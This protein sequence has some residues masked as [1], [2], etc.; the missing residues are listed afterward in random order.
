MSKRLIFKQFSCKKERK[1]ALAN[2]T[3]TQKN[4][5]LEWSW[6]IHLVKQKV[7]Q[8]GLIKTAFTQ[9]SPGDLSF[10]KSAGRSY[11]WPKLG[12]VLNFGGGGGRK[13]SS[14]TMAG[15]T[16]DDGT[17]HLHLPMTRFIPPQ[18]PYVLV[19][20]SGMQILALLVPSHHLGLS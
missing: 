15:K 8:L 17:H 1:P 11:K 18:C 16:T 9:G 19:C 4:R 6:V 2:K 7:E 14:G 13:D 20:L 5:L 12:H 10:R 3:H